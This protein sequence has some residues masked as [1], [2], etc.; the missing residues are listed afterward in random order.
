MK[1]A[2]RIT[3]ETAIPTSTF[4][5]IGELIRRRLTRITHSKRIKTVS[6]E[7]PDFLLVFAL[8]VK[9]GASV[10]Q[11]LIY[12]KDKCRGQI[13][14]ELSELVTVVDLGASL[15]EELRGI[16]QRLPSPR[17]EEFTQTLISN[18]EFGAAISDALLEQSKSTSEEL[19][20]NL[21][22]QAAS[23][24][25]KMLIPTIFLILPITVLFAIFPSL[26]MLSEAI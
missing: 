13:S 18:L 5:D 2:D 20:R 1:L 17:I 10:T 14:K 16:S 12:L 21:A 7:L 24:E 11:T 3:F 19:T 9:S 8:A 23:N 15:V 25:T 6:S 4:E 26:A 22:K